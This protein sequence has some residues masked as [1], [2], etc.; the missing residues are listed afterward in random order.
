MAVV[1]DLVVNKP[2]GLSPPVTF[3]TVDDLDVAG[4]LF[5]QPG[6]EDDAAVLV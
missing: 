4:G 2:L 6:V 1:A 5:D 3:E